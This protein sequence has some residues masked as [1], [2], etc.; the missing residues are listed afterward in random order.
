MFGLEQ[1]RGRQRDVG[2][3]YI[4]KDSEKEKGIRRYFQSSLAIRLEVKQCRL[5]ATKEDSLSSTDKNNDLSST[6]YPT[7]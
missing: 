7:Q 5:N 4:E 6:T 1:G 2:S 3:N